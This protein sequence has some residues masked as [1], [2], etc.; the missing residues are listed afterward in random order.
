MIL[1]F[2]VGGAVFFAGLVV[3]VAI[4]EAAHKQANKSTQDTEFIQ[5]IQFPEDKGPSSSSP[6]PPRG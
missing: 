3:G 5:H 1:A 2:I 6:Y 4:N